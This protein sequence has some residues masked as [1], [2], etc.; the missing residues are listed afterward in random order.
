MFEE[1]VRN[2]MIKKS[3]SAEFR[4]F[5]GETA[6]SVGKLRGGPYYFDPPYG[7]GDVRQVSL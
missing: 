1:L 2:G 4:E 5:Q 3:V 6:Y 7:L